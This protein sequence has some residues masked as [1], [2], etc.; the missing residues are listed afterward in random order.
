MTRRKNLQLFALYPIWDEFVKLADGARGRYCDGA[1]AEDFLGSLLGSP[2]RARILRAFVFNQSEPLTLAQIVKR[3]GTSAKVVAREIRAL[4]G[5]GIVR[6]A[7]SA[8]APKRA[9]R[10][11]KKKAKN[12]G[13]KAELA[14]SLDSESKHFRALSM[15]V[16]EVSPVRYDKITQ[17]LKRAGK[18]S[19]VI[20]SG[21]FMGDPSRPADLLVAGDGLNEARIETAVR[22]LEPHYGREIRYAS[23]S[24]PEFRYRLTID[25]R[26]IR[27]TLDFPHL[28]LLDRAKIL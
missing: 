23:F 16:H 15:F 3:A 19:V 14:W 12:S 5:I 10:V 18:T 17:A 21:S 26:L 27:D 13:A 20:I 11:S 28:V 6:A 7:K 24:V 2:A 1:M 4:E 25:D 8:P 22:A 9:W